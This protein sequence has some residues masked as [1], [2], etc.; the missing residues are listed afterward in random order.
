MRW[1][2]CCTT[3]TRSGCAARRYNISCH[4][5]FVPRA[6]LPFAI[7][8]NHY[9]V[10]F[11]PRPARNR[12]PD[13]RE[14]TAAPGRYRVSCDR[15]GHHR[16]RSRHSRRSRGPVPD[17]HDRDP[18]TRS[19]PH[20]PI[21]LL[22]AAMAA[23]GAAYLIATAPFVPKSTLWWTLPILAGNPVLVWLWVRATFDDDFVLR[24]WHAALLLIVVCIAFA[25]SLGLDHLAQPR[26]S[27]RAIDLAAGAGAGGFSCRT[28]GQNLECRSGCWPAPAAARDRDVVVAVHW[29]L[30]RP[31]SDIDFVSVS[32][33]FS[34]AFP[35]RSVC[36]P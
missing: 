32:P 20:E 25:V 12:K 6:L 8:I 18:G 11:P 14:R 10:D 21:K 26:T 7:F 29:P 34:E 1:R 24:R 3:S 2:Q 15:H 31:G 4:P 36:W 13:D 17:D 19:A 28:N 33:A 35:A 27:R 9:E 30:G 22:G 23:C 5:I 16:T